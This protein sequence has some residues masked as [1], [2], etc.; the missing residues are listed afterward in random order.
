MNKILGITLYLSRPDGSKSAVTIPRAKSEIEALVIAKD[1]PSLLQQ[2]LDG[3]NVYAYERCYE[4]TDCSR[5]PLHQEVLRN[6]PE[7]DA[8]FDEILWEQHEGFIYG[9]KQASR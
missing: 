7:E 5:S 6:Q 2:F 8:P 4:G 9:Y 1:E 3:T